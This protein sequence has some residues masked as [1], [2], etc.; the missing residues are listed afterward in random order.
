MAFNA[1]DSGCVKVLPTRAFWSLVPIDTQK[2]V[3]V[4][5]PPIHRI[6]QL[7]PH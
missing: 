6:S 5:H 1:Q 2:S 7:L 3:D 4:R